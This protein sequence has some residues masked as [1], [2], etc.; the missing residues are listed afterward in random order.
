MR[1]GCFIVT[2]GVALSIGA[3]SASAQIAVTDPATTARNAVTAA[4]KSRVLELL[5]VQDERLRNMARRLS[6]DTTLDT[7]VLADPPRWRTYAPASEYARG[8][9]ESLLAGDPLG[10]EYTRVSRSRQ[11]ATDLLGSLNPI[12]REIVTR[13]LATI[14]AADSTLILS[15]HQAGLLRSA[16]QLETVAID[17]LEA[18]VLD[19]SQEQSATAVLDKISAALLIEAR[20]K[21]ARLE[22]LTG[23]VEQLLVENKRAR[24]AEAAA[25]NMQLGRLRAAEWGSEGGGFLAG[26]ASDLR[27]WRQP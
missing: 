21:Q 7:Y 18:D 13:A 19:P 27:T 17:R 5:R 10:A 8:Y 16:G 2:A 11:L 25:L 14:D 15:T 23:I 12:A 3:S 9:E 20:Q 6:A 24:D 1:C 4:L 22:L 26:A